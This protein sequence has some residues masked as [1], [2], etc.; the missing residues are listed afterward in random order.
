[1]AVLKEIVPDIG[2]LIGREVGSPPELDARP[3]QQ[4]LIGT[5]AELFRKQNQPMLLILED[6]HWALESLPPLHSLTQIVSDLPLL[7]TASYRDDERPDL[8]SA[9]PKMRPMMLQRLD[10]DN[11]AVLSES[12]LGEAGRHPEMIALLQRETEGNVFF[13][14]ETARALAQ[15]A[16]RLSDIG[17]AGLPETVFAGGVQAVLQR[18]LAQVP[19]AARDF[20]KAA[21][22]IGRQI[23]F[24]LLRKFSH[25]QDDRQAFADLENWLTI[26]ANAAV[27]DWQDGHWRFAHD[28]LREALIAELSLDDQRGYHR[29]AAEAIERVYPNDDQH[30]AVLA[31]HWRW[32]ENAEKEASYL[33]TAAQQAVDA[34]QMREAIVRAERGIRLVND[35][36]RRIQFLFVLG[37]AQVRL[38]EYAN[39]VE[40]LQ[41]ALA[42]AERSGDTANA[43]VANV[44]ISAAL[45][46]TGDYTTALGYA[47]EGLRQSQL[48]DDQIS[49][50]RAYNSIANILWYKG[51]QAQAEPYY[52]KSYEVALAGNHKRLIG[53]AL[54][55]LGLVYQEKGDYTTALMYIRDSWAIK[56]ELGDQRG[57]GIAMANMALLAARLGDINA[58]MDYLKRGIEIARKVGDR[59]TE[60]GATLSL[61]EAYNRVGELDSAVYFA[62]MSLSIGRELGDKPGIINALISLG[63][64]ALKREYPDEAA[65]YIAESLYLARSIGAT[66]KLL[67][68]LLHAAWVFGQWGAVDR[69]YEIVDMVDQHPALME[70]IRTT[71]MKLVNDKL[72]ALYDW[73]GDAMQFAPRRSAGMTFDAMLE[74]T[75]RALH[76]PE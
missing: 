59:R 47:H 73:E 64:Y 6:L 66:P 39:G 54:N 5:L 44:R 48:V 41:M 28:K 42:I 2:A 70:D 57:I 60:G 9:L 63:S 56:E 3:A 22:V 1:V 51:E 10:A 26:C 37:D 38:G 45:W 33:V 25:F 14:V 13:L 62:E 18:R 35:D 46:E 19:P 52:Q 7:I 36:V 50:S 76:L 55:N 27:L 67:E 17:R 16:G 20:L 8:P 71:M 11:I 12:M 32:A 21:A 61:S 4:R 34:Q 43:A 29:R 65:A 40:S 74:E 69:A 72:A 24:Q 15:A 75:L 68:G 23:D 53:V 30:A 49:E 58:E 31:D